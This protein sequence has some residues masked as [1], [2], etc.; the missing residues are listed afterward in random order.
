MEH[1]IMP[2]RREEIRSLIS[3]CEYVH[4]LLAKGTTLTTDEHDVV[5]YCVT[6]LMDRLR[7]Y[8]AAA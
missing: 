2:L 8:H 1:F 5:E 7:A 3:A 4:A 6:E